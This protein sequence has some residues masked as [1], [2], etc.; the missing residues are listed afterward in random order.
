MEKIFTPKQLANRW[1]CSTRTVRA[2][3]LSGSLPHFRV[4]RLMRIPEEAVQ[5]FE[6]RF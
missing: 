4:G 5:T 6:K 3:V 2:V 1:G